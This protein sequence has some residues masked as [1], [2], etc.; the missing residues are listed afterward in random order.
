MLGA[1]RALATEGPDWESQT[2]HF[3]IYFGK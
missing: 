3:S 1:N 2:V